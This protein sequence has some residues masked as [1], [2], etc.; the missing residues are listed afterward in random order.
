MIVLAVDGDGPLQRGYGRGG[1]AGGC[2]GRSQLDVDPDLRPVVRRS[3]TPGQERD[4]LSGQRI[5]F[6]NRPHQFVTAADGQGGAAGDLRGPD[7]RQHGLLDHASLEQDVVIVDLPLADQI[8]L[9]ELPDHAHPLRGPPGDHC[10]R[11]LSGR[12]DRRRKLSAE[13]PVVI[14]GIERQRLVVLGQR[15][16]ELPHVVV[17]L[18]SHGERADRVDPAAGRCLDAAAQAHLGS[19]PRRRDNSRCNRPASRCNR[20]AR[21]ACRFAPKAGRVSAASAAATNS[22]ACQRRNG[23]RPTVVRRVGTGR[24]PRKVRQELAGHDRAQSLSSRAPP[25]CQRHES[26]WL[27][28]GAGSTCC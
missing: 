4:E 21:G 10:P 28:S 15:V 20:P 16:L 1:V 9:R 17:A 5:V 3:G 2:L 14:G 24:I 22:H 12:D 8:R 25:S 23:S 27:V 13:H 19:L 26:G 11:S 18:A 7:R 6:A